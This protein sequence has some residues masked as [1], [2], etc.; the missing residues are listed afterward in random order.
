MV[1]I[2]GQ[3]IKPDP[4][5]SR[6]YLFFNPQLSVLKAVLYFITYRRE[7]LTLKK[8]MT[9]L[10][11]AD[12]STTT[13]SFILRLS[14]VICV[15]GHSCTISAS[16]R[17]DNLSKWGLL[18][19]QACNP[20]MFPLS[21]CGSD[22]IIHILTHSTVSDLTSSTLSSAHSSAPAAGTGTSDIPPSARH[23]QRYPQGR[24]ERLGPDLIL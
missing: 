4:R 11:T 12:R 6:S 8:R 15:K 22:F 23:G 21:I 17:K 1:S 20:V 7:S 13:N 10:I 5:R 2:A 19:G 16:F 9:R 3:Q 14:A 24:R 18:G